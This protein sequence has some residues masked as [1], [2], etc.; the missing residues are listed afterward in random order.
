MKGSGDTLGNDAIASQ[1]VKHIIA[2]GDVA[3]GGRVNPGD[4]VKDSG[5]PGA[6]GT[7][8]A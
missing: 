1:T 7:D 3:L 5:F 2:I 6:V 8:Q 4:H